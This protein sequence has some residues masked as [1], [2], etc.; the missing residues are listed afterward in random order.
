MNLIK[1][2]ETLEKAEKDAYIEPLERASEKKFSKMFKEQKK[3]VLK[4]FEKYK[5]KLPT[6]DDFTN[7]LDAV[8]AFSTYKDTLKEVL[9]KALK[10]G[11][12]VQ[13]NELTEI[14]EASIGIGFDVSNPRAE[15]WINQR[16]TEMISNIDE[17]TR[18]RIKKILEDAAENGWN[19]NTTAGMINSEFEQFAGT[20]PQQHIQSRAHLIAVTETANAFG[21]GNM[22]AA[23]QVK[24]AGIEMQKKWSNTGDSRVSEGCRTNSRAGWIDIDEPFPSGDMREPRF[25]G[26]RCRVLYERKK[27]E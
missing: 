2:I 6:P 16:A 19:Y 20:M 17:T 13:F 27:I 23:Q 15:Q 11:G 25:P 26:C 10:L 7:D 9:Q 12:E 24:E 4:R 18:Q 3:Q 22:E 21:Q 1:L 8:F 14:K 5:D